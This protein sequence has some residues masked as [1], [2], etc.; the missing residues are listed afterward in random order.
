MDERRRRAL[1]ASASFGIATVG[2]VTISMLHDRPEPRPLPAA[3]VVLVSTVTLTS[4]R[5]SFYRWSPQTCWVDD[6]VPG[7]QHRQRPSA[8]CASG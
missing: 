8:S 5:V 3:N 2:I 6:L 1:L 4:T 7:A